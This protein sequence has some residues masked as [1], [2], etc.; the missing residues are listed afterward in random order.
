MTRVFYKQLNSME[1][2]EG[3][4]CNQNVFCERERD[5]IFTITFCRYGDLGDKELFKDLRI[6][7]GKNGEPAKIYISDEYEWNNADGSMNKWTN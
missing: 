4:S 7:F 1:Q 6:E 3:L 2:L 5:N